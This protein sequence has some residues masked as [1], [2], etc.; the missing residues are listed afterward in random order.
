MFFHGIFSKIAAF[1]YLNSSKHINHP[2]EL[3]PNFRQMV[4]AKAVSSTPA[5]KQPLK[6]K[7]EHQY[8]PHK[9][10][11][12]LHKQKEC[13]IPMKTS[14]SPAAA[15]VEKKNKKKEKQPKAGKANHKKNVPRNVTA[16]QSDKI[17]PFVPSKRIVE[18]HD[19]QNVADDTLHGNGSNKGR[20]NGED[21]VPQYRR[22]GDTNVLRNNK[23][24]SIAE[25]INHTNNAVNGG[26]VKDGIYRYSQSND[27]TE[28]ENSLPK[29]S[30]PYISCN[31]T[32]DTGFSSLDDTNTHTTAY[33]QFDSSP[34]FLNVDIR[35]R[36]ARFGGVS[37]VSPLDR[38]SP[39]IGGGANHHQN[40]KHSGGSS[41]NISSSNSNSSDINSLD[42]MEH[43][44]I[45]RKNNNSSD[46]MS[47][48]GPFNFRQLLRPTQG[49]TE[50]LRKRKGINLSLTPPPLQKGKV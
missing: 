10:F 46:S 12:F 7:Q 9:L 47:Y 2:S 33:S 38:V 22:F 24:P 28:M 45:H 36:A 23:K 14:S 11:A 4:A 19:Y 27:T 1:N 49:P 16:T 31:V 25:L 18:H 42:S 26:R 50:S 29:S 5:S 43:E 17:M 30:S 48:L 34:R 6:L 20:V 44:I 39:P 3:R 13:N 21:M 37:P 8:Q 35:D 15:L 41:S 40:Y 32:N